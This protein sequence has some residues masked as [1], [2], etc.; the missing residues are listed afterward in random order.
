MVF[1][2]NTVLWYFII[3]Q[4]PLTTSQ[5]VIF[6]KTLKYQLRY[7][8]QITTTGHA[9]TYTYQFIWLS[10]F[11]V[12]QFPTDAAPV[13]RETIPTK[14]YLIDHVLDNVMELESF[15]WSGGSQYSEDCSVLHVTHAQ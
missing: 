8:C 14:I 9:I 7:Y 5:F 15:V 2:N 10:Q 11:I 12:L 6:W 3:F 4:A 13:S 1:G